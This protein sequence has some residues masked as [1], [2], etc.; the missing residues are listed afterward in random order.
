M[1][2][3]N[4]KGK[5]EQMTSTKVIR[6]H[7]PTIIHTLFLSERVKGKWDAKSYNMFDKNM[8]DGFTNVF[9]FERVTID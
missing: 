3:L 6:R 1:M 8:F 2:F 5:L 9:H 7:V 4:E